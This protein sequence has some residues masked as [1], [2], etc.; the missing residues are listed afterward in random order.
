[1]KH[2]SQAHNNH[3]DYIIIGAGAAGLHLA[4]AMYADNFFNDKRIA[5][6]D[7]SL[8]DENDKTYCFWEKTYGKW[9]DCVSKTWKHAYF[10][11]SKKIQSLNLRP[12]LYKKINALD[13]YN[14]CKSSLVKKNASFFFFTEEVTSILEDHKRVTITT[15]TE[16]YTCEH[17]FDSRLEV[18]LEDIKENSTYINQSFKGWQIKTQKHVFAPERITMMDYNL[19]WKKSTSFMYILPQSKTEALLEYTLFAPFTISDTDFD[20]QLKKYIDTFYPDTEYTITAIEKG[21]IPMTNYDF[22]KH[23]SQKIIKI[24][25]AGGWVKASTGYSFKFAEKNSS[26][27]INQ[28]K[29]EQQPTGYKSPWRFKLY[30]KLLLKILAYDNTIGPEMF[31]EMYE[32]T[33]PELLFKFMD[34][35]TSLLEEIEFIKAL[36]PWP[37]IKAIL[38]K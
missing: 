28:L 18:S 13:F 32:N 29:K 37:F 33:E 6:F 24:G 7:K 11:D 8:K 17:A 31:A 34:E 9:D 38:R 35:E 2:N 26:A 22:K 5:I 19:L 20:K 21:S 15:N 25:T 1:M 36:T 23:N 10:K 14:F 30:D 16:E 27:I 4:M 3:F 12:Y